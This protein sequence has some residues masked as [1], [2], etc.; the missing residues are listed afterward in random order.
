MQHVSDSCHLYLL[1]SISGSIVLLSGELITLTYTA[2]KSGRPED[3]VNR[4]KNA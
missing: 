3:D 4:D 2:S 1:L